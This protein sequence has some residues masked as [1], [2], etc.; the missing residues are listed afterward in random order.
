VPAPLFGWIHEKP[1]KEAP[2]PPALRRGPQPHQLHRGPL[3]PGKTG[4]I[5]RSALVLAQFEHTMLT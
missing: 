3:G 2:P 4:D 1:W 5:A